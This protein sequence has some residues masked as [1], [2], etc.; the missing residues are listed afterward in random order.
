[1]LSGAAWLKAI[2]EVR[3]NQMRRDRMINVTFN[4]VIVKEVVLCL[5]IPVLVRG[6][7]KKSFI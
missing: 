4:G 3:E 1:M 6:F 7:S 2:A 5:F